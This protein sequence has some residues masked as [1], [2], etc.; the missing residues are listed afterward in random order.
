[1]TLAAFK[2]SIANREVPAGLA[3]PLLALW[4]DEAGDWDEAHRVAQDIDSEM[5]ARIHAY[6]HRKEGDI[7]NAGY[8]YGRAGVAPFNGRLGEEWQSLVSS[9]CDES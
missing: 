8:W 4:H 1:M 9:L 5:G 2:A 6:L 7:D 3:E